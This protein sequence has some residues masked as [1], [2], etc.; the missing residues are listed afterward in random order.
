VKEEEEESG[1]RC[2]VCVYLPPPTG[3]CEP[4]PDFFPLRNDTQRECTSKYW[5]C[6]SL[7]YLMAR[8]S[9]LGSGTAFQA[10]GTPQVYSS[11]KLNYTSVIFD[12]AFADLCL[13]AAHNHHSTQPPTLPIHRLCVRRSRSHRFCLHRARSRRVDGTGS[14]LP[15][16]SHSRSKI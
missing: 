1:S 4:Y 3:A 15:L 9:A 10:F 8:C 5:L 16:S 6:F 14:A 12:K 2:G 11:P 7:Y 13:V